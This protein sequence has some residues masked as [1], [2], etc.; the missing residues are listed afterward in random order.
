MK[1]LLQLEKK[2]CMDSILFLIITVYL[3]SENALT[4]FTRNTRD[5]SLGDRVIESNHST[6]VADDS[7]EKFIPFKK[8][9][10]TEIR[11]GLVNAK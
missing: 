8:L 1:G 3:K 5:R 7:R 4:A 10:F 11:K 6:R 2:A 9:S